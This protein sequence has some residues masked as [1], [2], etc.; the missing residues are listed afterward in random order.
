MPR[1]ASGGYTPGGASSAGGVAASQ[2]N[3]WSGGGDWSTTGGGGSYAGS[4]TP[5]APAPSGQL[6][7][8]GGSSDVLT[9]GGGRP[10]PIPQGPP[11][12]AKLP[13]PTTADAGSLSL[14]VSS[15]AGAAAAAQKDQQQAGDFIGGLSN[16]LFGNGGL[17]AGPSQAIQQAVG[18][19][20]GV[21]QAVGGAGTA[22]GIAG[23]VTS[24]VL[25]GP[26]NTAVGFGRNLIGAAGTALQH[27]PIEATPFGGENQAAALDAQFSNVPDSFTD[28][29]NQTKAQIEQQIASD[30]LGA[31]HLKTAFVQQYEQ[32]QQQLHPELYPELQVEP[33]S[34][35]D[36][37][38]SLLG[39]LSLPVRPIERAVAGAGKPGENDMN[40]LQEIMAVGSGQGQFNSSGAGLTPVEQHV[41]DMV[42]SKK[43][44]PDDALT[45]LAS[46]NSG[47]SHNAALEVGGQ[48]ALD[49]TVWGSVGAAGIEKLG[50]VGLD[51]GI[52]EAASRAGTEAVGE[53]VAKAG[54]EGIAEAAP[55]TIRAP[56]SSHPLNVLGRLGESPKVSNTIKVIGGTYYTPLQDSML[57]NAAKMVRTI[58]DPMHAL[59]GHTVTGEASMDVTSEAATRV[60]E[61]AYG[62]AASKQVAADMNDLGLLQDLGDAKATYSANKARTVITRQFVQSLVSK[63]VAGAL[64]TLDKTPG[65]VAS[66][67]VHQAPKDFAD[68]LKADMV[69][70][71]KRT[72]DGPA[73]Q[74]LGERMAAFFGVKDAAEWT[75][76]LAA[77]STDYLGQ[78]HAATYGAATRQFLDAVGQATNELGVAGANE[79][80]LPR[81]I[82]LNN[83]TLT[84]LGARSLLQDI[85]GAGGLDE[86]A[87]IVREAQL[88]HPELAYVKLDPANLERSIE[89]FTT[90][91]EQQVGDGVLPM[92]LVDRE[93][94]KLPAALKDMYSRMNGTFGFG[95]RP[96][97][98]HLWNLV[99]DGDQVGGF[100]LGGDPWVDH[101]AQSLPAYR[102]FQALRYNAAGMPLIG[103]KVGRLLDY[104]DAG[105]KTIGARTSAA[106]ITESAK[107]RWI[108]DM[109]RLA[110]NLSQQDARAMFE[111]IAE[112]AGLH[113]VTPRGLSAQDM[114]EAVKPIVPDQVR[115]DGLTDRDV[116]TALVHAYEGDLRF[117]GLTQKFT[118]KAKTMWAGIVGNNFAGQMSENLYQFVKYKIN[119]IFQAQ[120]RIEPWVLNAMRGS[121]P[122][123]GTKLDEL[124]RQAAAEYRA[125]AESGIMRAGDIDQA[126]FSAYAAHGNAML[127]E[128]GQVGSPSWWQNL[129]DIGAAKR[130]N[131]L[132]TYQNTL[133][134]SMRRIWDQ[135]F[136]GEWD[137]IVANYAGQT[138]HLVSDGEAASRYLAEQGLAGDVDLHSLIRPGDG[139]EALKHAI[140]PGF[141]QP[142]TLGELTGLGLNDVARALDM[143]TLDGKDV[144]SV[145]DLRAALADSGSGITVDRVAD[146]LRGIGANEDYVRRV[147]NALNFHW[148]GFWRTVQ[149]AYQLDP[150]ETSRLQDM[151]AN[152][153]RVRNMTPVDY[154]SQVYSPMIQ[155]GSDAAVQSLGSAVSTLRAAKGAT[156][157]DLIGQL[158]DTFQHHLDPSGQQTMVDAF[159]KG[160]PSQI[161]KAMVEGQAVTS[162]N[163]Q[164]TLEQLRGGWTKDTTDEFR[165]RMLAYV[166]GT[167]PTEPSQIVTDANRGV[168]EAR[169]V[170]ADYMT[171][172]GLPV[173]ERHQFAVDEGFGQRTAAAY[174]AL[175]SAGPV[176]P[177]KP[178]TAE[179]LASVGRKLKPAPVGVDEATVRAYQAFV[180][181]SLAQY[182]AIKKAGITFEPTLSDPYHSSAEMIADVRDNHRLK[183][184]AGSPEHPLMTNDQN[185]MFRGVHDYMAHAAEGNQFGPKGEFNAAV[186]HSQ[187]YSAEARR[188]MLTETHGQN[189]FVNFSDR[190]TDDGRTVA[191]VNKAKPGSIYAE[192]KAGLL[193]QNLL[194]EFGQRFIGTGRGLESNPDVVR[195]AQQYVKWSK[196]VLAGGLLGDDPA[197]QELLGKLDGIPTGQATPANY[198][199]TL[200]VNQVTQAQRMAAEDAF[201]LQYFARTRSF[202]ERS[203]NH[204]FFGLYPASYMWGK[205][206]PEMARFM[207][208]EPFGLHTGVALKAANDFAT[209]VAAQREMDPNFQK[210]MDGIGSSGITWFLGYMLP[211]VPW[212][213][214]AAAPT[215]ARDLAAQGLANQQLVDQGKD[216]KPI[217]MS[218]LITSDVGNILSPVR[219]V[220][221]IER[222]LGELGNIL[223]GGAPSEKKAAASA[224]KKDAAAQ[225]QYEKNVQTAQAAYD[226]TLYSYKNA[227]TPTG[228]AADQAALQQNLYALNSAVA[229]L[230]GEYPDSAVLSQ[231]NNPQQ[232]LSAT[233]DLRNTLSDQ[234][235]QLKSILLNQHPLVH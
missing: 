183:V 85:K 84:D 138:G 5:A 234:V 137:K 86:A 111:A 132:R 39:A 43:W 191:E 87:D 136:P 141:H 53:S 211:S 95:F 47:F 70:V 231:Y 122:A 224:A 161:N 36:E 106:T 38:T 115:V 41:Y 189:S 208:K 230:K 159:E 6:Y 17:L 61:G 1:A 177:G 214:G 192:Q 92:E 27:V 8:I 98:D 227:K 104:A 35:G 13:A 28:S 226:R 102:G 140:G 144:R 129:K 213:V 25:S 199:H 71:A 216:P 103:D 179:S 217:D 202:L 45:Y 16:A 117:V 81:L 58:I 145:G 22:L 49:P 146:A 55:L 222:P 187:M 112:R 18:D 101:V 51:L 221:Q 229:V 194:D 40:R 174:D 57:G 82:L 80:K 163:L 167:P 200:L 100:A 172:R 66:D 97:D 168:A 186:A 210:T 89:K 176:A 139:I 90:R 50:S 20:P 184:F 190:V 143:A 63:G 29:N 131:E 197:A 123:F 48:V 160:L 54:E 12:P 206:A 198:M 26:V 110:P 73:I 74:N 120:E 225:A 21:G 75:H 59:G 69:S 128:L 235:E 162:Q 125:L 195:A 44:T 150:S 223:N 185:I 119:P 76:A 188:A 158:A 2:P 218:K 62:E 196:Q 219:S 24:P 157:D 153:A 60:M 228:L 201:R 124:G 126:E 113:K 156:L 52:R 149:D 99:R 127:S 166:R 154:L 212:D 78:L 233:P 42:S 135:H 67:L 114:W 173:P 181:E 4:Y 170:A 72:W 94:A 91:L 93:I 193:P 3:L 180:D 65:A 96:E 56:G 152:S 171:K 34:L 30:P 77:K 19:V 46:N 142:N 151:I 15:P 37:V 147:E 14:D 121:S 108:E 130:V 207:A 182:R 7:G 33:G 11:A 204:P 68:L 209:S 215:W 79:L 169:K 64:K 118:G 32:Q 9:G 220:G 88:R 155:R 23:D 10:G 205:V 165:Q 148:D 105:V 31:G 175:P 133:G 178:V 164:R 109:S 107:A 203:I 116:M 134:D 232:P 83:E